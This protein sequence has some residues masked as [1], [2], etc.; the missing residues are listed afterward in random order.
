MRKFL[1]SFVSL[2]LFAAPLF[3][4]TSL[5]FMPDPYEL[6]EIPQGELRHVRL[7]GANKSSKTI[8]IEAALCQGVGCSNFSFTQK[9]GPK[10]AF[11]VEFDF[12]TATMEGLIA[13]QVVL[14]EKD[15]TPHAV[16]VQG[17]VKAPFLF[18]EKMFDLGYYAA[19]EKRKWTFY[20]WC[21]DQKSRPD[22][23]LSEE[24]SQEFSARISDVSLNVEKPDAIREG[25][26]VKAQK[27]ELTLKGL[28]KDPSSK[29]KSV[30][31]IVSFKSK[32]HPKATPEILLVGYWK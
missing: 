22:L 7:G 24:F 6:G 2:I 8:E 28:K 20:V 4:E 25:G 23:A 11:F 32:S 16:T 27:I 10:E 5:Q 13:N 3:A 12:S 1:T 21:D 18:S 15:G 26:K 9:I 19:G 14:V 29:Q 31:R 30:S 17:T